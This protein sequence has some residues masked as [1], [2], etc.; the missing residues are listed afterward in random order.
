[1]GS[2]EKKLLREVLRED[3]RNRY[4]NLPGKGNKQKENIKETDMA[5]ILK[6]KAIPKRLLQIKKD[7]KMK[8]YFFCTVRK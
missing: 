5:L 1:M 2:A 7:Q 3:A 4:R 6:A 8:Y